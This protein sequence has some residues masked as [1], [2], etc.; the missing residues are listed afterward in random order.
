MDV[1]QILLDASAGLLSGV[2]RVLGAVSIATFLFPG[3][4]SES[5]LIGVSIGVV[6]V[7]ASN[8]VGGLRNK[9]PYVTYS[10]DYTP[11]FLFS[12]VASA[13]FPRFASLAVRSHHR[14]LHHADFRHHRCCILPRGALQTEQYGALCSISRRRG[15]HGRGS[16]C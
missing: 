6:T 3:N 13:L 11:I 9:I 5:F 10:T 15:L 8:I 4:L 7:I 16:G 12:V 1:K 14:S 2:M